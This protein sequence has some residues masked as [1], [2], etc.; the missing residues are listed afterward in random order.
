M[1]NRHNKTGPSPTRSRNTSSGL[2][3][4]IRKRMTGYRRKKDDIR[5]TV[6]AVM[7]TRTHG[8]APSFRRRSDVR[9][10]ALWLGSGPPSTRSGSRSSL[11]PLH[12][13]ARPGPSCPLAALDSAPPCALSRTISPQPPSARWPPSALALP[14]PALSCTSPLTAPQPHTATLI[15][16][17]LLTPSISSGGVRHA[18]TWRPLPPVR[19]P[20]RTGASQGALARGRS[21]CA[22][23]PLSAG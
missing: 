6:F 5:M 18:G 7:A 17:P 20:P 8:I 11:P 2:D 10:A 14:L 23:G 9:D 13:H 19:A 22:R 1:A 15:S 21:S 16:S 4:S 12:P 3:N